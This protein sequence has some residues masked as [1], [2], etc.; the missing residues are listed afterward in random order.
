MVSRIYNGYNGHGY[1]DSAVDA[2]QEYIYSVGSGMGLP[3]RLIF[4]SG[5]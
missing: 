2:D 1:I 5:V 3:F 4:I